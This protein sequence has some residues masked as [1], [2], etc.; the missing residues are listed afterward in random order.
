[1]ATDALQPFDSTNWPAIFAEHRNWL[2]SVVYARVKNRHAVEE[3]LQE[4]ALAASRSAQQ[5]E[6]GIDEE[7]IFRWLYRVAVR[8]AILYRRKQIR[9][10]QRTQNAS[11]LL[12]KEQER[13]DR[14]NEPMQRVLLSE[15]REIVR[16]AMKHLDKRDCEI[17]ML[18][19]VDEWS[20]REISDRLGASV[21]A[22][23]S[24]LLRARKS[25]RSELFKYEKDWEL[26]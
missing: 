16:A 1:M 20:C 21:T 7:G 25:L 2:S 26:K 11:Q 14:R 23:K 18:K 22:I 6:I 4:T 19:Y 12:V 8:Q 15:N 9:S 5:I 24:R 13:N 17:L 10:E 3:V